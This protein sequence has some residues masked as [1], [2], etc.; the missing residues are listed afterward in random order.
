MEPMTKS[1]ARN[2]C[3][4][5][6]PCT[7]VRSRYG[8]TYEGGEWVALPLEFFAVPDDVSGDDGSCMAWFGDPDN[9]AWFGAG[10]TPTAAISQLWV[11]LHNSAKARKRP[12]RESG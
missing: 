3:R 5:Q 4:N 11:K 2:W 10:E 9:F 1:E 6:W 7:V 8:G 12:S